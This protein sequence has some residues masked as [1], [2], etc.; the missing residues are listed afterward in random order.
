M[1]EWTFKE[2]RE[3]IKEDFEE[4]ETDREFNYTKD[5]VAGRS[6]VELT[7]V[8]NQGYTEKIISYATVGKYIVEK[9]SEEMKSYNKGKLLGILNEYDRSKLDDELTQE[10][11]QKLEQDISF[12]LDALK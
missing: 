9:C 1:K 3:V 2:L 4:Y 11:I 7:T 8:I 10:E 5:Q 12:V 6:M